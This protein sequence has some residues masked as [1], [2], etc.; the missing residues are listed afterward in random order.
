MPSL[1]IR[2]ALPS[3]APALLQITRAAFS[4][5]ASLSGQTNTNDFKPLAE[6]EDSIQQAMREKNVWIGFYNKTKAIGTIRCEVLPGGIAYISRFAVLPNWQQVGMGKELLKTAEQY[7]KEQGAQAVTLHTA[8][9]MIAQVRFYTNH[10]YFVHSTTH[11]R[12]YIRGLF[13][14]EL[15]GNAK[16]DLMEALKR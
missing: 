2:Q 3:D 9:K 16:Y 13:I 11:D 1:L 6:T 10:S 14:K 5:Y 8:T 15:T 4:E 12:G 7:A